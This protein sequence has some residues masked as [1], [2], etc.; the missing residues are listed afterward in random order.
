MYQTTDFTKGLR[1][2][3][4]DELWI[5]VECQ[6]INP[7]KGSAFVKTKL[8]SLHTGRVLELNFKAGV[9]KLGIPD[10]ELVTMQ[11]LYSDGANY[12]FMNE[13]TFDQIELSET[14]IG[15]SKLYL[16][17]N[18]S[19]RVTV[20][21]GKPLNVEVDNFVQLEVAKTQPNI[22]GD[23]SSGGSKPATM[24]TG[25]TI[26]VPFHISE[27]DVIKIDTRTQ[28]YIEKVK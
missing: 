26:S 1:V 9:D 16:T 19:V 22:K 15:D 2:E 20:Y 21:K 18:G 28:K 14:D 27:G 5:I 6:H 24:V 10:V 4:R 7:G 3:Y 25:L 17:E 8:K 12:H 11:Y 13:K 23:T